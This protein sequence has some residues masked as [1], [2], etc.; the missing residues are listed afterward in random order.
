VETTLLTGVTANKQQSY[1]YGTGRA[2]SLLH[3]SH[4]RRS[5]SL[6]AG[7]DIGIRHPAFAPCSVTAWQTGAGNWL[8]VRCGKQVMSQ[9]SRRVLEAP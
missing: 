1:W 5:G 8:E 6:P 9:V 2:A 3:G 7:E 4:R